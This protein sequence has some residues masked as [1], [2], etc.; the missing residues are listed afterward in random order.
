M[1]KNNLRKFASNIAISFFFTSIFVLIYYYKLDDK[2]NVYV[3]LINLVSIDRSQVSEDD[4]FFYTETTNV[5]NNSGSNSGSGTNV[6]GKT[7]SAYDFSQKQ[8]LK[9]PSYGSRYATLKIDKMGKSLPVYHGDSLKI[10]RKGVGHYVGSYFPGENG[11][12]ILAGHNTNG[13]F[14]KLDKIK[15]GDKVII[16]ATYASFEYEVYNMKVVKETNLN[17]FKIQHDE[18]ILIMYTCYPINRSIVGR[19]TQRYVV[20]AKK[21]GVSNE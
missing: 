20:Y 5:G 21:V 11:T 4:E 10:L 8:L 1:R 14:N 16:K 7:T 2:V 13:M 17:A 12:I 6:S 15:K 9:Y 19:Q 3:S 18:E